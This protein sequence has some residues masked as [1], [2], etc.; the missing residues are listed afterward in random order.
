MAE[1]QAIIESEEEDDDL[2]TTPRPNL[3]DDQESWNGFDLETQ[4]HQDVLGD[5]IPFFDD[6]MART[7][8]LEHAAEA[9]LWA[10]DEPVRKNVRFDIS[11]DSDDEDENDNYGFPDLFV[12]QDQLDARF[13]AQIEE[14]NDE[15]SDSFWDLRSANDVPREDDDSDSDGSTGTYSSGYE[16]K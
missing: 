13:L 12:P 16:C 11:D 8:P 6:H 9:T 10:D 4:S 3:D 7:N 15:G 1:E 5:D 14:E 2:Q